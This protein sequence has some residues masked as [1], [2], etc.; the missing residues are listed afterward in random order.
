MSRARVVLSLPL[1]LLTAAQPAAQTGFSAQWSAQ[2][3]IVAQWVN[4]PIGTPNA[5]VTYP[6]GPLPATPVTVAVTPTGWLTATSFSIAPQVPQPGML[7]DWSFHSSSW[8]PATAVTTTF[9]D[10]L[11]TVTGPQ[12]AT[13]SL[14]LRVDASGDSPSQFAFR[15]DIGN[16]GSFEFDSR[17]SQAATT[18]L[19]RRASYAWDFANGPL[20]VR[21]LHQGNGA[22]MPQGFGLQTGFRPWAAGTTSTGDDCGALGIAPFGGTG[23]ETH[24]HLAALPPF[25]S[26]QSMV[27]RASGIGPFAAFLVSMQP[28]TVTYG[29]PGFTPPCDALANIALVELGGVSQVL[30]GTSFR[31]EWILPVPVLPP[32]L[33]FWV[34]HASMQLGW[35]GFSNRVRVQT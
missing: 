32:G 18:S 2:Q 21:V 16:D 25:A 35:L 14:D 10:L 19:D 28:N 8:V 15:V 20:L 12:N 22:A 9:A 26:N 11:L 13:G 30:S 7:F 4:A 6:A 1:L 31:I 27:L 23:F 33:D 24:Y 17:D 5:T 29:L 3:P 34:Q